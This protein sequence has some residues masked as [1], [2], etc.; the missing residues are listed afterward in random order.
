MSLH[1]AYEGVTDL[2]LAEG[3]CACCACLCEHAAW[4]SAKESAWESGVDLGMAVSWICF[5]SNNQGLILPA[6]NLRSNAFLGKSENFEPSIFWEKSK[7]N[8]VQF[9]GAAGQISENNIQEFC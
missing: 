3:E 4:V 7:K 2:V 8:W 6:K 1:E 5:I 9:F